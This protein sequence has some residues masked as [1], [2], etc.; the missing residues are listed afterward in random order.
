MGGAPLVTL[1]PMQ[2]TKVWSLCGSE[3]IPH[4]TEQLSTCTTT[5]EPMPLEHILNNEKPP[6]WEACTLQRRVAPNY[7]A[8]ESPHTIMKTQHNEKCI[9]FFKKW[10]NATMA[11]TG[12]KLLGLSAY[13][14]KETF[15]F[16]TN[17]KC[18]LPL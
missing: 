5:T 8:R 13:V 12:E 3:E 1:W 9:K 15:D 6:Q 7:V 16:V 17:K 10:W 11:V 2:G 14:K 18:K 4:A